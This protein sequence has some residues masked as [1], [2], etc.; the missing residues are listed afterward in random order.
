MSSWFVQKLGAAYAHIFPPAA[1]TVKCRD[2]ELLMALLTRPTWQLEKSD[3]PLLYCYK[4]NNFNPTEGQLICTL[5]FP[6]FSPLKVE[7]IHVLI[8][9]EMSLLYFGHG[10]FCLPDVMHTSSTASNR[11]KA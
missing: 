9:K 7:V 4:C 11:Q 8:S 2:R 3:I 5:K 10:V 6:P 1:V